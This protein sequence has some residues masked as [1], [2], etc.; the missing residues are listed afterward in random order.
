[1][2]YLKYVSVMAVTASLWGLPGAAPAAQNSNPVGYTAIPVPPN[3]DVMVSVPYDN[4]APLTLNDMFPPALSNRSFAVSS[5]LTTRSVVLEYLENPI[6]TPNRSA[7]NTY[8]FLRQGTNIG[9]R[10]FGA[11]NTVDFGPSNLMANAYVVLR[12][13]NNGTNTLTYIAR[14]NVEQ[15]RLV[16][17][18]N[19]GN[20]TND[21]YVSTGRPVRMTLN[22]LQLGGTP[23]FTNSTVLTTRD[24]ILVFDNAAPGQN[25]SAVATYYYLGGPTGGWRKFG[26]PGDFGNSNVFESASGFIIRTVP[27]GTPR[28]VPW[29]AMAPFTN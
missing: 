9:W 24:T 1:M 11:P 4:H 6:N 12:N 14:G 22:D 15:G 5:A 28:S 10:K 25:K 23:A 17:T 3:T 21:I 29:N 2:N 13:Q 27:V 19:A 7:A 16:R 20:Y 8:Y 26:S 18:I